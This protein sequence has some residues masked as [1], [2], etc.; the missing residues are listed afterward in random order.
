MDASRLSN[1]D[2][3]P[4][5]AAQRTWGTWHV[6]A[7]WIGMAVCVPTYMLAA[8][9][10]GAGM[11]WWQASLTVALGNLVV[12]VPMILN[13]HAGTRWGVPFPVLVRSSFGISGAHVPSLA[14]ALVACGWFGIQTWIGGAAIHQILVSAG[15]LEPAPTAPE[16]LGP[17]GITASQGACFLGFWAVHVVIVLRGIDSIR[18]LESWASPFLLACGVALLGWAVAK[19]RGMQDLLIP[20]SYPP[21]ASFSSVFVPQLTAMVGFW[22]TL[23]LNIPDFTRYCRGQRQQALGQL[24]GL[25]TTMTLFAFIGIA[26]TGVSAS[27]FGA[28]IWDPVVLAGRI[29]AGSPLLVAVALLALVLATL[30]TNVAANIVSPANGFSNLWPRRIGFRTGAL[31]TCVIGVAMMPWKLLSSFNDYVFTWLIGYS[32]LLGPI[33]GIMLCDYYIIRRT[34]LDPHA[35]YEPRGP[36]R[37]VNPAAMTALL[38][39]VAPNAPGFV[40]ALCTG[41]GG[42]PPVFPRIFDDIYAYAWFVGAGLGALLYWILRAGRPWSASAAP[43]P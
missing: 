15:V 29:G 21:G 8:G 18:F 35:L 36:Y 28:P 11:S 37:G 41:P 22:A 16:S 25:P 2:L 12:T 24:L 1:P 39:A 6:A 13:G 20:A 30:T 27:V 10:I 26:V 23:S 3:A 9:M 34:R 32:A 7:L 14:R 5:T 38:L 19:A 43:H 4:T 33:A 40:N 42:G 17:L 31:L